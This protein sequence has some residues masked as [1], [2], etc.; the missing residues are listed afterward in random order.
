MDGV[1]IDPLPTWEQGK[2]D[3][4]MSKHM[5]T[6]H[7]VKLSVLFIPSIR[8]FKVKDFVMHEQEYNQ[9][10]LKSTHEVPQ[11]I[12][13]NGAPRIPCQYPDCKSLFIKALDYHM[14]RVYHEELK[15]AVPS[16]LDYRQGFSCI[17]GHGGSIT[18]IRSSSP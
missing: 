13:I 2:F 11:K 17:E 14:H 10:L 16:R 12:D 5:W 4:V 8:R 7:K 9:R 3:K 18:L 15:N 1:P 6:K